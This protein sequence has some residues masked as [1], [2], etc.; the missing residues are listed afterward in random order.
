MKYYVSISFFFPF[1]SSF[2]ATK[3]RHTEVHFY[4][5]VTQR[6]KFT[7]IDKQ[8]TRPKIENKKMNERVSP[9]EYPK[10]KM[11]KENPKRK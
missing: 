7:I 3:H 1:S 4:F 10:I 2:L 5:K 8:D 11:R 6:S 9:A